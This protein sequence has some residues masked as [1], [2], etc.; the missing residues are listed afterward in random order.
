MNKPHLGILG[1]KWA[2]VD[3]PAARS[4]NYERRWGIPA[5]VRFRDHV[6]NLVEGAADEI[7]ELEFRDRPQASQ[8]RAEGSADDGGLGNRCVND[9][10]R[11]E[12]V[13]E[14]VGNLEG[15]AVDADIFAEAEDSRIALHFFPD[16]LADGFEI[17]KLRH[18]Y[19]HHRTRA[20]VQVHCCFS[21][22]LSCRA[23]FRY[24]HLRHGV[25]RLDLVTGIFTIDTPGCSLRL[26]H[27]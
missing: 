20:L 1:M 26:R 14:A 4:A 8:R 7:H 19:E 17:S 25:F 24:S 11:P 6:D 22:L 13:D 15:T 2:T 21:F 9:P 18:G 27:G 16:T 5:V 3:I 10:F 12:A 23:G